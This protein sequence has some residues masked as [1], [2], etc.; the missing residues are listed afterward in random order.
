MIKA[1]KSQ[2][3]LST[4]YLISR[5]YCHPLVAIQWTTAAKMSQINIQ[6][7]LEKYSCVLRL[8]GITWLGLSSQWQVLTFIQFG[9]K[10]KTLSIPHDNN[11][12][13]P[14]WKC[15]YHKFKQGHVLHIMTD[16]QIA[17]GKNTLCTHATSQQVSVIHLVSLFKVQQL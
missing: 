16:L 17:R 13:R 15:F 8:T 12:I 1:L 3:Q 7:T 11:Y 14:K 2:Q 4:S 10:I 9:S 5:T 6:K